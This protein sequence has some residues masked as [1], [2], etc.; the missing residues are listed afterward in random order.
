MS[1]TFAPKCLLLCDLYLVNTASAW[2]KILRCIGF[3]RQST[4]WK[5][6]HQTSFR[7]H[8]GHLTVRV[9]SSRLHCLVGDARKGL[10]TLNQR[11][12]EVAWM[13]VYAW[14]ELDQRVIDTVVK[15]WRELV[16]TLHAS[17]KAKGGYW[18]QPVLITVA[19]CFCP[20]VSFFF[21]LLLFLFLA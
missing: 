19:L 11:R 5:P 1:H 21:Y 4:Y 16:F 7:P 17:V 8:G 10:P 3:V 18:T 12:W 13:L 14:D 2:H 20:V 6:R 9:E 15:Q